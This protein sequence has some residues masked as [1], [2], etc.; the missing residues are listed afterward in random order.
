MMRMPAHDA[1]PDNKWVKQALGTLDFMVSI[2]FYINET[3]RHADI[4]LPPTSPLERDHYD[5]I[6]NLLAVRNTAKYSP[7]LFAP[8]ADAHHDWQIML[9]LERRLT[10]GLKKRTEQAVRGWLKPSGIIDLSLRTGPYGGLFS[11][12]S[13]AKL[14]ASPSGIDL[15]ALEPALPQRL[16]TSDRMI[17]LAPALLLSDLPRLR[18][19]L[20]ASPRVGLA[21]IGRRHLR[22]NNSWLHNSTRLVRG[23]NRCTLLVHPED[24]ARLGLEDGTVARIRS[25][26]GEVTAPVELSDG[27]MPGV[28][29]LPHGWGHGRQGVR[30]RVA[31]AHPGV[32][33]N[34][35]TDEQRVDALCG[36]A[37]LSGVPV[38]VVPA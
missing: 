30:L 38:E 29:S 1:S 12:L 34:D 28:V 24:A 18:A 19:R 37:A 35:L 5:L 32:S 21:L 3:T 16:Y 9:E 26:V 15:G 13:L 14:K 20:E 25:R 2:D 6:F 17:H 11:G 10:G 8:H 31:A 27:I 7:A 33:L 4:I 22:S 36:V 23:K